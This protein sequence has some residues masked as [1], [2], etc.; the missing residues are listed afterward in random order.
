M[1]NSLV[2]QARH[3]ALTLVTHDASLEPYQVEI[4]WT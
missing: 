3:E 1:S 4:L 2:A